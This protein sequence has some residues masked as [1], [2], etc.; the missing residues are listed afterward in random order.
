[1]T[2]TR[3]PGSPWTRQCPPNLRRHRLSRRPQLRSP[4]SWLLQRSQT[5]HRSLPQ[6]LQT[7]QILLQQYQTAHRSLPRWRSK[8]ACQRLKPAEPAATGSPPSL[9][10]LPPQPLGIGPSAANS[11]S[12]TA[13]AR[14][15][16]LLRNPTFAPPGQHHRPARD[17]PHARRHTPRAVLATTGG[18]SWDPA[19]L[20]AHPW[21][22]PRQWRF[23]GERFG[24]IQVIDKI[25]GN[26]PRLVPDVHRSALFCRF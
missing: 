13:R 1:M 5:A 16:P 17:V 3:T 2:A 25:A 6:L 23:E 11:A 21:H 10:D 14:I 20:V 12:C 22:G 9:V 4:R 19:R 18:T 24:Q 8:L 15:E 26:K 7:V